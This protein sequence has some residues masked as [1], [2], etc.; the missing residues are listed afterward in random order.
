MWPKTKTD[1]SAWWLAFAGVVGAALGAGITGWFSY[2]GQ[3]NDL[4]A[5]MIELS[6]NVLR[7]DP[8]SGT[9]PLRAWAIDVIE[10][11]AQFKFNDEQKAALLNEALPF[12]SGNG[13]LVCSVDARTGQRSD[14]HIE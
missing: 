8:T 6:V 5:K 2:L 3:K 7:A 11:R 1:R 4:D 9:T 14:C 12:K 13:L 10:K